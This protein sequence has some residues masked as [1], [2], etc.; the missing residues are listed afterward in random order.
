MKVKEVRTKNG[1]YMLRVYANKESFDVIDEPQIVVVAKGLN[2]DT[3][4]SITGQEGIHLILVT[5]NQ[6]SLD[7]VRLLVRGIEKIPPPQT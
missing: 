5:T 1:N 7:A 6:P 2:I 3:K 4:L